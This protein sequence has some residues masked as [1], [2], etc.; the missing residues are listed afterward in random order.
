MSLSLDVNTSSSSSS[1][2]PAPSPLSP[3]RGGEGEK[4]GISSIFRRALGKQASQPSALV[5]KVGLKSKEKEAP[6]SPSREK[7]EKEK[8][9]RERKSPREKSPREKPRHEKGE[10]ERGGGGEK[11]EGKREGER[12]ESSGEPPRPTSFAEFPKD[13]QKRL[14]KARIKPNDITGSED[15]SLLIDLMR[16]LNITKLWSY[17]RPSQ[18]RV[19]QWSAEKEL[20]LGIIPL[21]RRLLD[22]GDPLGEERR[23]GGGERKER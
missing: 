15:I 7:R 20:D 17:S 3:Q 18:P 14:Q 10:G 12:E 22:V 23:N 16:F 9:P 1:A 19:T 21:P 5:H 6:L 8:S 11:G 2:A 4:K 13:I